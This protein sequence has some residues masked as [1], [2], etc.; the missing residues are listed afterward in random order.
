M[1]VDRESCRYWI[2]IITLL[3]YGLSITCLD[4]VDDSEFE[5]H[6]APCFDG[7]RKTLPLQRVVGTANG[8]S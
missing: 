2:V 6:R 3:A 7:S 5:D 1:H 4:A 8:S